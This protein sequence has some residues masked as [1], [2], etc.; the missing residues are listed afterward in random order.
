MGLLGPRRNEGT[1]RDPRALTIRSACRGATGLYRDKVGGDV[2][3]EGE[4]VEGTIEVPTGKRSG[5]GSTMGPRLLGT[6]EPVRDLL[7]PDPGPLVR[8]G[9]LARLWPACAPAPTRPPLACGALWGGEEE[10]GVRVARRRRLGH[11]TPPS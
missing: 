10:T 9:P 5:D 3:Y 1:G 11:L 2:G 6:R 4:R 7:S 8:R